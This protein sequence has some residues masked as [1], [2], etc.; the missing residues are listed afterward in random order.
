[1]AVLTDVVCI[2][3]TGVFAGCCAAVVA[4]GAGT[5][6]GAVIKICWYPAIGCMTVFTDIIAGNVGRV[7]ARCSG[8][9][10]TA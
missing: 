6:N 7:L 8:T 2:D 10:V 5:C 9:V 4:P 1:M 3:M